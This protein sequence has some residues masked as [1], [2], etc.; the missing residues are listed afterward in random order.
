VRGHAVA[1]AFAPGGDDG[2]LVLAH[3]QGEG[4]AFGQRGQTL[5]QVEYHHLAEIP[6]CSTAVNSDS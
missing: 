5:H 6:C 4:V 1:G 3:R 2:H